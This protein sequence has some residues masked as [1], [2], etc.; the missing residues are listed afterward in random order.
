MRTKLLLLMLLAA[1]MPSFAQLRWG[2]EAGANISHAH[3]TSGTRAGFN[4]GVT[5]EY[6]FAEHWFAD[7]AL[8]FGSQ[9]FSDKST[10]TWNDPEQAGQGYT[11]TNKYSFTPYY[12]TLPVRIGYRFSP[13]EN[14]KLSVSAGPAIGLGLFGPGKATI[15]YGRDDAS[16]EKTGNVFTGKNSWNRFQYGV[17]ARVGLELR[18]HYTVGLEYSLMHNAGVVRPIDNVSNFAINLGYKF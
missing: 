16:K 18:N 9:P 17:N 6:G 8:K 14:M 11:Y 13:S 10:L 12:L 7:A 4:I 3:E 15:G 1:V 5:G 2:V